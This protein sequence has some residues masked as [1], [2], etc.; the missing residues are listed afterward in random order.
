LRGSPRVLVVEPDEEVGV[1]DVRV[2]RI[3]VGVD[4]LGIVGWVG[5]LGA[6]ET[7]LCEVLPLGPWSRAFHR[8]RW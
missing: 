4:H 1:L 7:A 6:A 2:E 5:G 3:G 8:M